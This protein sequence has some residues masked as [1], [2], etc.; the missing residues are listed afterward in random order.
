MVSLF[1]HDGIVLVKGNRLFEL[2]HVV[3]A[4]EL[5]CMPVVWH[6]DL[7]YRLIVLT[8]LILLHIKRVEDDWLR[9][10]LQIHASR[11][12]GLRRDFGLF[13]PW[14]LR[15]RVM[16][17]RSYWPRLYDVVGGGSHLGSRRRR[18]QQPHRKLLIVAC[19]DGRIVVEARLWDYRQS[20][21]RAPG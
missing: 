18:L 8:A 20:R 5:C 21:F 11:V 4:W 9:S 12:V 14:A 13:D 17:V 7:L 15:L 1:P 19:V 10:E 3:H 6:R 2:V 16:F